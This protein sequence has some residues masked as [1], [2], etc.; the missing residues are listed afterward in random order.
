MQNIK[1]QPTTEAASECTPAWRE[2]A[3]LLQVAGMVLLLLAI[4]IISG[5][6]DSL[7]IMKIIGPEGCFLLVLLF[8]FAL[9]RYQRLLQLVPVILP[10]GAALTIVYQTIAAGSIIEWVMLSASLAVFVL[11]GLERL[12]ISAVDRRLFWPVIACNTLLLTWLYFDRMIF[13]VGRTHISFNHLVQLMHVAE[14]VKAALLFFGKGH[15][16]VIFEITLL[17]LAPV[18]VARMMLGSFVCRRRR[19]SALFGWLLLSAVLFGVNH[20]RFDMVCGHLSVFEYL[21]LRLDLGMLP[22]PDHPA[23]RQAPA[24]NG[25]LQQRLI[26]DENKLF[27]ENVLAFQAGFKPVNLV[28]IS[29]ESMRRPEFD[30]LMHELQ[31]FAGRGLLLNNHF[32]VTNITFSSFHSIFRSSFP[33]NLA[34]TGRWTSKIPLE[35]LLENASYSTLLIKPEK[36]NMPGSNFWGRRTIEVSAEPKWKNTPL[37]LEKLREE[38]A[39]PGYKAIHAYLYNM[40]YNYYYPSESEVYRPVIPEDIN[41]FLMQP[42]GENFAGLNNRYA[43]SAVH[44][45]RVLAEFL[46]QAE[47]EG[48]FADTLFVIFG[49]HGESLGESGFTAHATGPHVRQFEAPAFFV[50]AGVAPRRVDFP[51]TH[52]DLLPTICEYMGISLSGSFGRGLAAAGDFP[53]LQLDEAVSG[54]IVVRHRDYMSVFDLGG[55]GSL[56]WLITVSNEFAIDASVAGFYASP[57]FSALAEVIKADADFI[58]RKLGY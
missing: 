46:R 14:E 32:S 36:I 30:R 50:G 47:V 12:L 39:R 49:D 45:D 5:P 53:L 56:K 58:I 25:L 1:A 35:Q 17:V 13:S 6:P 21:P 38:L 51:T 55:S 22:V 10:A 15:L 52:A 3:L 18:P 34:Y 9:R 43:N 11:Y 8:C 29:V 20:L 27:P 33:I 42:D 40:H 19:A 2:L 41:L 23:L 57:D 7:E 44:T 37:V 31:A 16:A 24:L 48:R 28:M 4:V 26:L 54:R